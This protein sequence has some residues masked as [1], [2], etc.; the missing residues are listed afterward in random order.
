MDLKLISIVG[1]FNKKGHMS[2]NSHVDD[3][4]GVVDDVVV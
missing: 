1:I 3:N 4:G 2:I